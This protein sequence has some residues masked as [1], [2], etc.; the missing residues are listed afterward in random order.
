MATIRRAGSSS[1]AIQ[2]RVTA[3]NRFDGTLPT[4]DSPV[5]A[6]PNSPIYKYAPQAAGGLFYWDVNESVICGQ[7][8]VSLGGS[9]DVR[10]YLVNLDPASVIAGSP[11][12]LAGESI[13]IE[14]STGVNFV[15]LDESKFRCLILP[16]QA[17]QL[18][19]TSSGAAQIAQA[20]ASIERTFVR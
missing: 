3:G 15:A 20:V 7:F 6:A 9:A 12:A 5:G 19:T 14:E 16:F 10:L 18:V 17:L 11:T 4:G 8:H 13:L 2:Q 1:T